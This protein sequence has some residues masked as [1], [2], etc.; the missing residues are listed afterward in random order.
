MFTS[1]VLICSLEGRAPA[2]AAIAPLRRGGP[3][4]P[5]AKCGHDKSVALQIR[6]QPTF[7]GQ[8]FGQATTAGVRTTSATFLWDLFQCKQALFH[9]PP[10]AVT[11]E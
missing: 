7:C 5:F 4:R 8:S 2:C 1:S 10:G 6:T 3:S 11:A 9:R